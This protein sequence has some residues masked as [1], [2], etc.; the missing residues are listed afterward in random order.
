[1]EENS[2]SY[3]PASRTTHQWKRVAYK[4]RIAIA[5]NSV[6]QKLFRIIDEK[7]TNLAHN[8]DVTDKNQFLELVDA[9][10][11]HICV[12]KTHIDLITNFDW[13]LI[14]KLQ[15]YAKK[16]NFLIFEDRKFA[17]IGY[18][19]KL[20]YTKGIYRIAEWADMVNAH[21]LTGRSIIEGLKQGAGDNERGLILIPRMSA[22]GNFITSEY[23]EKLLQVAQEQ[24]EFVMGLISRERLLDNSFIHLCPGI[25]LQEG[26]DGLGQTYVTPQRAMQDGVDVI[27]VGRGIYQ[28]GNPEEA[29]KLYRQSGWDAYQATL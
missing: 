14:E 25:K 3:M 1:M 28:S 7:Q 19:T 5:R 9:V 8:P 17:D 12:L 29:T 21:M 23:T 13:D 15:A 4:D 11:P 27:I 22:R 24:P 6:A 20:Q 10:G 2:W 18:V 26:T 16:H